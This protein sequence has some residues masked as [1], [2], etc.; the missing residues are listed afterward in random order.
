MNYHW[1]WG[2]FLQQVQSGEET[3]LDWLIAGLGWTVAVAM[4]AWLIAVVLG[5]PS[6]RAI[7]RP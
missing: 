1:N 6:V 4:S 5:T 7:R 3:Y 2:I